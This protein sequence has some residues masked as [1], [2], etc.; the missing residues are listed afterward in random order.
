MAADHYAILGV[1]YNASSEEIRNAYFLLARQYHPDANPNA[2]TESGER[3]IAIQQAYEILSH[4]QKKAE[5]DANFSPDQ[6]TGPEISLNLKYSRQV[7]PILKEPQLVY[8]LMDMFCMAELDADYLPPFHV[9]LVLDRSTSMQGSRMDMVK[10]SA[11]NLIQQLRSQDMLSVVTFS[12][13]ASVV[14][15]PTKASALSRSD[16]RVNLLQTGGATEI[17]Q[18]LA[19]GVDQLRLT[20]AA[21]SRQL[22]LLTD[23]NTYGDDD[24]CLKLAKEA[25]EEGISVSVIGIGH[26]WN[27][28]L[29]D[30]LAGLGGGNPARCTRRAFRTTTMGA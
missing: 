26:E 27:D 17:F 13:R 20:G 29:M 3:F 15:P 11:M 18:G 1:S 28:V 25:A 6:R 14:I 21:Y 4:P 24:K 5:Y 30:D 16:S 10:A 22:I 2:R 12:D 7:I 9:C 8:V 19:M 23:G